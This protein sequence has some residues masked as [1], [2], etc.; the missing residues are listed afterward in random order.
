MSEKK[1]SI[2]VIS[3]G[4]GILPHT[5]RVWEQRYQVFNPE[6]NK[7]GQRLYSEQDLKKAKLI[8]KLIEEGH[9]I[10]NLAKYSMEELESMAQLFPKGLGTKKRPQKLNSK[11]LLNYLEHYKID[12]LAIELQHIRLSVGAKEFLFDVVLPIMQN[13]GVLVAKGKY[14]VTQEHIISTIVREQL[15]QIYLPNSG[16][17]H[18][19]VALASPE[20]NL[21]E[22]SIIFADILCR[23]NRI[24]TRY[25]GSAHPAHCLAEALNIIKSPNLVLGVISSDQWD[26]DKE[27]IPYLQKLDRTLNKNLRV[28]LGGAYEKDFGAFKNISE[29]KVIDSFEEFDIY[30]MNELI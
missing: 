29:I 24:P 20:G 28:I 13:I 15:S 10:S 22:L 12:L 5:L 11:N 9:T 17:K 26:Y 2:K 1:L 25:L 14:T 3:N 16:P 19:E 30:L 6:R 4:C 23:A 7:N 8:A 21:H 27:I 18:L